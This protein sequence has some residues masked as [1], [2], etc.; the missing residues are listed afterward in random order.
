[1]VYIEKIYGE[2]IF[3]ITGDRVY[4]SRQKRKEFMKN[5]VSIWELRI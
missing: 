4:I 1:M 2:T 3:L 5:I